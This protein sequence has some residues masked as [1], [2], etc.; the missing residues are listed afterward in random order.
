MLRVWEIRNPP[1]LIQWVTN[2]SMHTLANTLAGLFHSLPQPLK[3][4]VVHH[5]HRLPG[6][7]QVLVGSLCSAAQLSTTQSFI[8]DHNGSYLNIHHLSRSTG[9]N[10]TTLLF[11]FT[12]ALP[13]SDSRESFV[14]HNI[15]VEASFP[16]T[17]ISQTQNES[18]IVLNLTEDFISQVIAF[19]FSSTSTTWVV[20]DCK[21]AVWSTLTIF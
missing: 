14:V 5:A 10:D 8:H 13:T 4:N 20:G 21:S 2:Q 12:G 16:S 19:L 9:C 15:C 1:R 7:L 3:M 17:L 11:L 18:Q 6:N